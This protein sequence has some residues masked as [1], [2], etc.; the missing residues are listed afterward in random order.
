[1]EQNSKVPLIVTNENCLLILEGKVLDDL[2]ANPRAILWNKEGL[3]LWIPVVRIRNSVNKLKDDIV[4]KKNNND[5][6]ALQLVYKI[7]DV[8]QLTDLYKELAQAVDEMSKLLKEKNE[9]H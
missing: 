1:M 3:Y 7:S 9:K 5:L 2:I 8:Q 6:S 4:S